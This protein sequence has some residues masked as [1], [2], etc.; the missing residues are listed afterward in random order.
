MTP[1]RGYH[2]GGESVGLLF[3][4]IVAVFL[5][6]IWMAWQVFHAQMSAV[7]LWI[8]HW[9]MQGIG[10]L[11][12]RF[13]L[14]DAQ[15]LRVNPETVRAD[16]LLRLFR[17]IGAFFMA[18]AVGVTGLLAVMCFAR[19][20]NQRFARRLD[21]E[22]LMREQAKSFPF[23]SWVVG[24]KLGLAGVREGGPRPADPALRPDEWLE[25]W[26]AG[27]KGGFD[28]AK[29]REVL[30]RQLGNPWTGI[31]GLGCGEVHAGGV[32]A[33]WRAPARSRDR[34]AGNAVRI[35][36]ARQGRRGG[37]T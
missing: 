32:R 25:F 18:P 8:A 13:E 19:A 6:W 33:A 21:L 10:L 14:A 12:H 2:G 29:A 36:P 23:I 34:T 22:G 16:Q 24:R 9:E 31:K 7:A 20:G 30:A 35:A 17:N 1:G 3:L 5:V 37:G 15:I 4:M 26:A 28:E 11:S 27:E